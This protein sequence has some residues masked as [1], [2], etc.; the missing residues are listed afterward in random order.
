VAPLL[1]ERPYRALLALYTGR[2]HAQIGDLTG[3]IERLLPSLR[4]G[5]LPAIVAGE[6]VRDARRSAGR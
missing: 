4:P 5:L 1:A 6:A 3:G 2:A